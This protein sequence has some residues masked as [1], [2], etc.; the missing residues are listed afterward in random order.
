[1]LNAGSIDHAGELSEEE[2]FERRKRTVSY[3]NECPWTLLTVDRH[4]SRFRRATE[5]LRLQKKDPYHRYRPFEEP[6]V[7]DKL[8]K[9]VGE[10]P[11]KTN[12]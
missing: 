9:I 12:A 3:L 7:S 10:K 8:L 2:I 4:T 1:V 5:I 6:L 11:Y